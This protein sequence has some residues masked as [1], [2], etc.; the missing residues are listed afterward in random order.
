MEEENLMLKILKFEVTFPTSLRYFEIL[1][2]L[3]EV[4][5]TTDKVKPC[6]EVEILRKQGLRV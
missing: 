1:S 3:L 5:A 6:L 2:H 4:G